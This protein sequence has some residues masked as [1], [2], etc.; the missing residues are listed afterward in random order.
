MASRAPPDLLRLLLR[1]D[2]F[3]LGRRQVGRSDGRQGGG[4][5]IRRASRT[6]RPGGGVGLGHHQGEKGF[7]GRG[8]SR[9]FRQPPAAEPAAAK[10]QTGGERG[11]RRLRRVGELCRQA[12]KPIQQINFPRHAI[13]GAIA[14]G[15]EI[16]IPGGNDYITPGDH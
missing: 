1:R 14:R 2:L 9:F 16:I 3:V 5:G 7:G 11:A 12:N 8:A 6:I 13:I 15:D 10:R 4:Q